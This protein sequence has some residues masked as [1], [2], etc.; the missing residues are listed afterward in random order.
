MLNESE[1]NTIKGVLHYLNSQDEDDADLAFDVAI[2]DSNGDT[3]AR[4]ERQGLKDYQLL[5]GSV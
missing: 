1:L 3:I 2:I 4:I 5:F